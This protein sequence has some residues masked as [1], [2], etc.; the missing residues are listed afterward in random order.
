MAERIVSPGVF[1]REKDLSFLPQGIAEIGAALVG[2]T[3]KG[4]A[5]VPTIVRNFNEFEEMFGSLDDRFYVPITAREYLRS[6]GTVTIVRILGIGGYSTNIVQIAALKSAT[7]DPEILLVLAP[8]NLTEGEATPLASTYVSGTFSAFTVTSGS[9]QTSASFDSTS[10]KYYRDVFP[11]SP[12]S[13]KAQG[14]D[15]PFYIYK[16]FPT[17]AAAN[18]SGAST[19]TGSVSALNLLQDYKKAITPSIHSQKQDGNS[20]SL[21]QVALRADGETETNKHFKVGILNVKKADEVAGS[22]YGTFSLQVRKIDQQTFA[23]TDDEIVEQFDNLNLDPK[24]TNFLCRRV[25]TR[26]ISVDSDGKVN[27]NGDAEWPNLS[28]YVFITGSATLNEG[29]F[30]KGLV[31][32]GHAAMRFPVSMS[33]AQ[34][35]SNGF[36][37]NTY[38]ST[39]VSTTTSQYDTSIFFGFDFSKEDNRSFLMPLTTDSAVYHNPSF[40][41]ED[42]EGAASARASMFGGATTFASASNPISLA[43]SNVAQRKFFVPLQGGFDGQNPA[44]KKN[45]GKNITAT[46]QQGLDCST[47]TSSGS[48]AYERGIKSLSNADEFDINMLATPGLIYSLHPSP[49]NLAQQTVQDRGDAFY[50]FDSVGW[51]DGITTA[52][53]AI[54][55][56]DTNYAATYYPWVKLLDDTVNIPV[57][58]PPSVVIPGVIAQNDRVAHEWFAPAGL[59]R[60]GLRGVL[61]AKTRLTHA[62]RDLLYENRINPIASFPGQG[63]VVFGQKTL[64]AAPSALDRINVRRLLIRLKKFIASS[65]RYLLFENNTVATR[66]R[67]LNIVN[68]YLDSVQANQGLTGFR[69]VMDDS[70]N[71]PDVI[72]RNQLVGQIFIQPARSVEFIVLDFVVEP[73]GATFQ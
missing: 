47:S 2:P 38:T 61:E 18:A 6:A 37:A 67:F 68:P 33:T 12:I 42:M 13:S 69:V 26:W 52:V 72:D 21:F 22:D 27:Y 14:S 3:K 31:P 23:T 60:G 39:Q 36:P 70:N 48:V 46:N 11:E 32:M 62:E 30:A 73:S 44:V 71:T 50:V 53:N 54:T 4:P 34:S 28:K 24:S 49:I 51:G 1:T 8:N 63:V 59:N 58:V 17:A 15:S 55:S 19:I 57:W 41:L 43:A 56:I 45:T 10:N 29:G 7:N 25:G 9:Y 35:S 5:F 64:Q 20:E 16:Q 66:A 40:S 65:S